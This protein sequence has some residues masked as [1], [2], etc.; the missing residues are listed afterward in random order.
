MIKIRS[1]VFETNS[2]SSHSLVI[3]KNTNRYLTF[4]E[5]KRSIQYNYDEETGVY[6]FPWSDDKYTFNRFP[7]KVL[8]EFEDKMLFLYANAPRRARVTKKGYTSYNPEYYKVTRYIGRYCIPGFKSIKLPRDRY[9]RPSCEAYN[10]LETL[11]RNNISWYEFLMNPNII[12]ICDGDEY[13]VWYDMK[14]LNLI[15]NI[16]KEIKF[17]GG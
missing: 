15:T 17:A 1:S 6:E 4:E 10:V 11:E 5:A 14:K 7:F 16:E 3:T 9:D 13:C 12:V 8:Q 2:S